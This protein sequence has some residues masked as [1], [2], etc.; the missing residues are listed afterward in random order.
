V[1]EACSGKY[2][3]HDWG[4]L[5]CSAIIVAAKVEVAGSSPIGNKSPFVGSGINIRIIE[6]TIRSSRIKYADSGVDDLKL[7]FFSPPRFHEYASK[8]TDTK[9]VDTM[10]VS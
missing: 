9:S 3:A 4:I 1:K 7:V 6:M 5:P 8:G 2:G 10:T